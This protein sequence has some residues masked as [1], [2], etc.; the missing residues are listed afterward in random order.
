MMQWLKNSRSPGRLVRPT[1]APSAAVTWARAVL[2]DTPR[3]VVD[4]GGYHLE[5]AVLVSPDVGFSDPMSALH[6]MASSI[7]RSPHHLLKHPIPCFS[8]APC[9]GAKTKN[10]LQTGARHGT[11]LLYL[12][13]SAPLASSKPRALGTTLSRPPYPKKCPR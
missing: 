11:I 6:W 5:S 3:L 13:S 12:L 1:I 7:L 4:D 10:W 2:T 9:Q 8:A